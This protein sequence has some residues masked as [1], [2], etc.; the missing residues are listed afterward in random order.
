[1]FKLASWNYQHPMACHR[2]ELNRVVWRNVKKHNE[3]HR[4]LNKNL[5]HNAMN[6][7]I[8]IIKKILINATANHMLIVQL[9]TTY[10][11][12]LINKYMSTIF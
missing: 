6:R 5:W 12:I 2:Q 1:M 9:S 8:Y 3:N 7:N 10:I 11:L 4:K